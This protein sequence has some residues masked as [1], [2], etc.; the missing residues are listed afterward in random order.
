M[1]VIGTRK[2]RIK[3]G[4]TEYTDSVSEV[5]IKAGKK[6]TDFMSF[7]EAM[8]GG[9]RDYTLKM[10]VRQDTA[11]SALWYLIYGSVGQS[12]AVS[13]WPNGPTGTLTR[14]ASTPEVTGT[15][16]VTE[17]DGEYLGGKAAVSNTA[18][19]TVDVEWVFDSKPT[20]NIV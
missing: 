11:S 5:T 9:A 10:T 2:A 13:Y 8:A 19:Q 4:G 18:V 3:I 14:S 17:P 20:I 16:T 1:P 12:V 15:V 7:A 6:D